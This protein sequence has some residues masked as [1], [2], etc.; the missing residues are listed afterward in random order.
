MD[1]IYLVGEHK[2]KARV[3]YYLAM[4]KYLPQDRASPMEP[5]LL[6]FRSS[7]G[8]IVF[9]VSYA[10]LVVSNLVEAECLAE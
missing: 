1:Y 6:N 9:V 8:F 3:K 2:S 5:W 4:E 10:V 7:K